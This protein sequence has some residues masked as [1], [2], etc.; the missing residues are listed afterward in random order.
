VQSRSQPPSGETAVRSS[1]ADAN[2]GAG[3]RPFA[4]LQNLASL[5]L[6]PSPF[7]WS[8]MRVVSSECPPTGESNSNCSNA[9]EHKKG[10]VSKERQLARLRERMAAEENTILAGA[11]PGSMKQQQSVSLPPCKRCVDR[12]VTP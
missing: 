11:Q 12:V 10:F 3:V 9:E 7:S 1:S 5:V 4:A 8:G 2:P 6:L